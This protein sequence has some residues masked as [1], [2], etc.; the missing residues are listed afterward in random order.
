MSARS[1]LT[2]LEQNRYSA[3]YRGRLEAGLLEFR[4]WLAAHGPAGVSLAR[5]CHRG[6]DEALARFADFCHESSTGFDV[7]KTH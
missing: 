4:R 3:A 6:L 1:H 7:A 5:G 2:K